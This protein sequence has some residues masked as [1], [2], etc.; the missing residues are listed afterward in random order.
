M[1]RIVLP[2]TLFHLVRNEKAPALELE[3]MGM[4]SS[5]DLEEIIFLHLSFF[6]CK[7]QNNISPFKLWEPIK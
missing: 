7:M 3:S 2:H 5:P 6:I 1:N 4:S